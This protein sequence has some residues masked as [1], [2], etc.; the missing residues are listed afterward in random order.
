MFTIQGI[1]KVV[2]PTVKVTDTFQKREFVITDNSS[3]YPQHVLFQLAQDKCNLLD[4]SREGDE[5]T[6][7]FNLRG[8][9]WIS[10]QGEVKHFNTLD[11]WKIDK[12]GSAAPAANRPA[13]AATSPQDE[14]DL[15]F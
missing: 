11:A 14:S 5:V 4:T 2:N 3:Q 8:R 9:E 1:L 7:S 12:A 13:P 15:P 6:V 10:P